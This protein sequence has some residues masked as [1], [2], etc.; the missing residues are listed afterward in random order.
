MSQAGF[1][2]MKASET[3]AF[4]KPAN[5]APRDAD[6]APK[7]SSNGVVPGDDKNSE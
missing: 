1:R 4:T 2:D 3:P 7:P 6:S 5:T